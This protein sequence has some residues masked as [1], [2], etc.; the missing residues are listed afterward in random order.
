MNR[1]ICFLCREK[2]D[3]Q[4]G[5]YISV[6]VTCTV[7]IEPLTPPFTWFLFGILK[8]FFFRLHISCC[9]GV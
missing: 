8:L 6:V 2:R 4:D 9:T 1:I 3:F 5:E 7:F